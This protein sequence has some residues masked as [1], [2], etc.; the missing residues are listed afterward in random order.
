MDIQVVLVLK[1]IPVLLDLLD[2]LDQPEIQDLQDG[3]DI[4]VLLD[5]RVLPE[6]QV[7]KE[8]NIKFWEIIE[9]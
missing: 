1:E 6:R 2:G 7:I 5:R 3:P 9:L 4:L 8:K